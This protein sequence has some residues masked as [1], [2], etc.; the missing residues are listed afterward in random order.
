MKGQVLEFS[1]QTNAGIISGDDGNRYT[2]TG[3]EWKESR[4]PN[5]G[6]Y[7]DFATE[8]GSSDASS[9]YLVRGAGGTSSL[10]G[11]TP[12]KIAA[13]LLAIFLGALGVH[14]F[15]LG[16]KNEGIIL[17]AIV[18]SG[19]LFSFLLVGL[20]WVWVPGVIGLIEGIIYL[21]KTDEE[22]ERVYVQ[23]RKPWF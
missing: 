14:K 11:D 17:L 7:V 9:I 21:T 1:I 13:G 10:G 23:G 4:P 16:Y 5:A 20:L 12:N 3:A 8:E 2:F 19:F 6:A 15:Y 18:G 22:F